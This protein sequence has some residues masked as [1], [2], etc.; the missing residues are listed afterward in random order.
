MA[1][2]YRK[3]LCPINFDDNSLT[4]I[5]EAAAIAAHNAG[6]LPYCTWSISIR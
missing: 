1:F 3:I 6:T 2:P 4:A 5:H